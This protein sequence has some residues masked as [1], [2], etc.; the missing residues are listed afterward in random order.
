MDKAKLKEIQDALKEGKPI[1]VEF[2]A[3]KPKKK[4]K[5]KK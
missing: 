4:P 1:K 3:A 5:K 2:P